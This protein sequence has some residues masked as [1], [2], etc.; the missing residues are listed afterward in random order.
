MVVDNIALSIEYFLCLCSQNR[1]TAA[2]VL[3]LV[4]AEGSMIDYR[5]ATDL[6]IVV[7]AAEYL[8]EAEAAAP[9]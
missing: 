5:F 3:D 8:V 9:G 6:A 4:A 1:M 2:G 7:V